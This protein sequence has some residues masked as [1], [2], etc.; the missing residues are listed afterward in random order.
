[1]SNLLRPIRKL[2][3]PIERLPPGI[4]HYISPPED[5]RNYRLHLRLEDDGSG[6][7]IIN[8]AT[9]LHL[10]QTGAEYAYYFVQNEPTDHVI[11][12]ITSRYNVNRDQ[13]EQDY[14]NLIERIQTLINTPDLDPVTYLDFERREPFI[15]QISAPY[16]LDCALSYQLPSHVSPES[17]PSGRVSRELNTEEWQ[18]IIDNAWKSGIPHI[19]FTGGEPTLRDDLPD[20]ITHAESNGQ[21]IGLLTDGLRLTDDDY[22]HT[23][24]QTGLDHVMILFNPSDKTSWKAIQNTLDEDIFVA[25]HITVDDQNQIQDQIV[26]MANMGVKAIS[27]SSKE[28]DMESTLEIVREQVAELNLELVWNLPVPYSAFNPIAF[29]TEQ[30]ELRK[31]AGRAWLYI[32]PDG[33]VLPTQGENRIL[34]NLLKDPWETI[35]KASHAD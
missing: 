4:Y 5:P 19:V 10:N 20:L 9:V 6:V 3:S 8:A 34:G 21:V 28:P 17:A 29:E 16:R 7:L 18:L 26:K 27:L 32:E 1:M 2:F 35:W 30:E 31:G 11:Q 12:K 25:V 15:G 14:Q 23:L 13:A 24:L 22:L 33:D